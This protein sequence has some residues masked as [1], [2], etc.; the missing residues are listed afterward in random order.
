MT[1]LSRPWGSSKG[2]QLSGGEQEMLSISRALLLNPRLIMLDERRSQAVERD[3]RH[4][5]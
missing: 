1:W 5:D 3:R 4:A 2:A